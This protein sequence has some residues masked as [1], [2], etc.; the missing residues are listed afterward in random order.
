MGGFKDEEIDRLLEM[1]ER[2]SDLLLEG[3]P[4]STWNGEDV[5]D[6]QVKFALGDVQLIETEVIHL[7]GRAKYYNEQP[8]L[9]TLTDLLDRVINLRK[10]LE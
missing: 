5:G 7:I 9:A 1:A 6:M 2:E 4:S 8:N 10:I 3:D